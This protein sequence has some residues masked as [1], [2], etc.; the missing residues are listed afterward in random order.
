M[1]QCLPNNLLIYKSH[2]KLV[3]KIILKYQI[4]S[5]SLLILHIP[6]IKILILVHIKYVM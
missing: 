5:T 6:N 4:V 1:K 2:L 3:S